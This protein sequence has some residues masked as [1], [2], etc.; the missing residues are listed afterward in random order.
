VALAGSDMALKEA[1]VFR[2]YNGI[3]YSQVLII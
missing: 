2:E 1:A 3:F